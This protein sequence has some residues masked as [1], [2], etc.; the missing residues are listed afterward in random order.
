MQHSWENTGGKMTVFFLIFFQIIWPL[1]TI[2][3]YLEIVKCSTF[4]TFFLLC[5]SLHLGPPG[6]S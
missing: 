6:G 4:T 5:E 1:S 2:F 3:L